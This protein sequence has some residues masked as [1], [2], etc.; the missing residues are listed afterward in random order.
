MNI[1]F[2]GDVVG[3]AGCRHLQRVLPDL[4]RQY[5]AHL[6]ICNGEN[7]AEGNGLSY[8]SAQMLLQ[9]GADVITTGNHLFKKREALSLLEEMPHV[10][11]PLNYTRAPG[12]GWYLFDSIRGQVCVVSLMGTVFMDGLPSPFETM[13]EFLKDPPCETVV[14]DFHAEATSEKRAMGFYLDGRVAAVLGTH[15]HVQTADAQIL[16]GGT[17]YITDAGMTGPVDSVLGVK[18]EIIL[19]RFLTHLPNRFEIASGPCTLCGV[20]LELEGK[21]A[22]NIASFCV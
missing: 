7:S 2:I 15:T 16:P 4:R 11:R 18:K 8:D 1:L 10:V 12:C 9:A 21:R 14:V 13:D 22:K 17:A 5:G 3:P 20:A 19:E 6:C